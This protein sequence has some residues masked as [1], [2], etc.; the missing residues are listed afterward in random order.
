MSR[1][2]VLWDLPTRLFHWALVVAVPTAWWTSSRAVEWHGRIGYVVLALLA[3][4]FAW[5]FVGSRTARFSAFVRDPRAAFD[6]LRSLMAPGPPARHAGHNPLGGYAVLALLGSLCVQAGTGLFLYDDELFW[7]PLNDR[8]GEGAAE[9]LRRIHALRPRRSAR[10][11]PIRPEGGF[12]RPRVM[13]T[14]LAAVAAPKRTF[15][16]CLHG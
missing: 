7:A 3:F 10:W 14:P 12:G 2:I 1:R 9:L 13:Q 6:H 8:V 16:S 5:G 11:N 15:S 4:R